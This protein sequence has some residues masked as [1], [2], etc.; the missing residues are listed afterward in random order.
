ML[1]KVLT[2]R[3]TVFHLTNDADELRMQTVNAQVNGRSLTSL[4]HF[5]L[6]LLLHLGNDFFN[7]SRVNAAV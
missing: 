1:Q 2:I 3:R 7:A 4:D 6:D 5:F